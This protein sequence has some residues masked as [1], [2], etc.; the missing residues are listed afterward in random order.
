VLEYSPQDGLLLVSPF[1]TPVDNLRPQIEH[2]LYR[3]VTA[4]QTVLPA[5]SKAGSGSLQFTTGCGAITPYPL[6]QP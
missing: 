5:I 2:H 6:E 3:S 1:E 4:A